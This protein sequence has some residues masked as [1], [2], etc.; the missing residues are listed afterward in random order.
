MLSSTPSSRA[1]IGKL[2]M[3]RLAT[4]ALVCPMSL[5]CLFR[6]AACAA[7]LLIIN[8][9]AEVSVRPSVV[10]CDPCGLFLFVGLM[11]IT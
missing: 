3:I 5:N 4:T 9:M 2:Y 10:G 1:I 6:Q 11:Y 7:D 8:G